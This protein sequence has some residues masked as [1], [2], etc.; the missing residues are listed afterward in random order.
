MIWHFHNQIHV[1]PLNVLIDT[2]RPT[3]FDNGIIG[4]RKPV[5]VLYRFVEHRKANCFVLDSGLPY[6]KSSRGLV[7]SCK[8][9][10]C[11]Y[12]LYPYLF[13]FQQ[14]YISPILFDT[15]LLVCVWS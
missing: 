4:S 6:W 10:F 3:G 1:W 2:H 13:T 15:S 5:G 7:E 9:C 8:I 12:S 11:H 14:I